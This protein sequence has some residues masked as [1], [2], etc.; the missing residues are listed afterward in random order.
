MIVEAL[1]WRII[2]YYDYYCQ[3]SCVCFTHHYVVSLI[4]ICFQ[5]L[6]HC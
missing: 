2:Y 4:I 6:F 5:F 3:Y 1:E